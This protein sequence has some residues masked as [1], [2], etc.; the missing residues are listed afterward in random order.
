MKAML[1]SKLQELDAGLIAALLAGGIAVLVAPSHG[2]HLARAATRLSKKN[3][4]P[5]PRRAASW[6]K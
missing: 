5:Q 1:L 3:T 4:Q 2:H 6:W